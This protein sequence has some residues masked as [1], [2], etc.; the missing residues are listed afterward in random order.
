MKRLIGLVAVVAALALSLFVGRSAGAAG[1]GDTFTLL[2]GSQT[3]TV[4]DLAPHDNAAVFTNGTMLFAVVGPQGA[5]GAVAC[6]I[7]GNGPLPFI[8]TPV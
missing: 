3:Y 8:I 1:K 5:S 6:T 4:V 7:D 2:C